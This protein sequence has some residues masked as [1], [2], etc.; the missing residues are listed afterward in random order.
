[1]KIDVDIDQEDLTRLRACLPSGMNVEEVASIIA[2]AGAIEAL[3]VATERS[4]APSGA[5][6]FLLYRVYCL[7]LAGVDMETVEATVAGVFKVTPRQARGMVDSTFAK[8]SARLADYVKDQT[9]KALDAAVDGDRKDWVVTLNSRY[10]E[11]RLMEFLANRPVEEPTKMSVGRRWRFTHAAFTA[12][13]KEYGAKERP[14][15]K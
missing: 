11:Y 1:L 14:E 13:A 6:D 2:K 9:V 15:P 4:D 7:I 5:R 8:Y 12:A 10:V 3:G